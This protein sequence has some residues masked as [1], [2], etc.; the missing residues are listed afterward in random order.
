M[1]SMSLLFG[2]LE[3]AYSIP[4]IDGVSSSLA[5]VLHVSDLGQTST[6]DAEHLFACVRMLPSTQSERADVRLP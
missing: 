4:C 5:A 1:F 2:G 3:S 6:G